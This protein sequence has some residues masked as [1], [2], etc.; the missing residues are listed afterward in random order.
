MRTAE[1]LRKT[2]PAE[3]RLTKFAQWLDTVAETHPEHE[4][5][6]TQLAI[7]PAFMFSLLAIGIAYSKVLKVLFS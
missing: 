7:S 6:A 5:K 2:H 3:K 1:L 4:I